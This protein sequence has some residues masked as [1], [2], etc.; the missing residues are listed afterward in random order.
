MLRSFLFL[1]STRTQ[2]IYIQDFKAF[3]LED[4]E[5]HKQFRKYVKNILEWG[6]DKR[7]KEIRTA[8]DSLPE[9]KRRAAAK[10]AMS[11]SPLQ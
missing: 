6:K 10:V 11:D 3:A 5:H 1:G 2:T 7:L 4:L 9:E 8:L